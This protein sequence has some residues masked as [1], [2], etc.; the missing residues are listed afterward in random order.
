VKDGECM[1][2]LTYFPS[3]SLKNKIFPFMVMAHCVTAGFTCLMSA[4]IISY[5]QCWSFGSH[6]HKQTMLHALVLF[7]FVVVRNQ[8]LEKNEEIHLFIIKNIK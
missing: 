4:I 1:H 5:L 6:V 8:A 7:A 3:W 2:V